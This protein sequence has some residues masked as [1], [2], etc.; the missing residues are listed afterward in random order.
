MAQ[1]DSVYPG[2][3]QA[4]ARKM[5]LLVGEGQYDSAATL[6]VAGNKLH[7]NEVATRG[8]YANV[9][10]SI[11]R[12]RG[13]LDEAARW[14]TEAL[15]FHERRGVK[16]ARV[17]A[18][19]AE[20]MTRVTLLGD[21]SGAA[22]VLDRA[23]AATPLEKLPVPTRPYRELSWV[24]GLAGRAT[25]VRDLQA[26]FEKARSQL[27]T[28]DDEVDRR[29]MRGLHALAERRN[30]EAARQFQAAD[31]GPCVACAPVLLAHAYDLAEKPD[32]ALVAYEKYFAV[33]D[34]FRLQGDQFYLAPSH[35]RAGE[36]YEAKGDVANAVKHYREFIELW[37]NADPELQ[38]KVA[39]VRRK[40]ARLADVERR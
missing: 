29:L 37:K 1:Y 3:A 16:E 27:V 36:L 33:L 14:E 23:L 26:S 6:L 22:S 13:R 30:D 28:L 12:T 18:A 17:N 35:K 31:E 11:A 19:I 15:G 39:E 38:P 20:A 5:E 4:L 25:N 2:L 40:V 21:R 24:Y 10:A 8:F 9:L 7:A 34:P 32:S